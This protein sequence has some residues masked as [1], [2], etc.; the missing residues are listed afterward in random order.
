MYLSY[1]RRLVD[2]FDV[3]GVTYSANPLGAEKPSRALPDLAPD[4]SCTQT[5]LLLLPSPCEQTVAKQTMMW[6][7]SVCHVSRAGGWNEYC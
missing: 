7:M 6:L 4:G 3:V 5:S 1:C 2:G